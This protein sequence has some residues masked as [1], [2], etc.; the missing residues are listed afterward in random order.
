MKLKLITC[1]AAMIAITGCKSERGSPTEQA[2]PAAEAKPEAA[3]KTALITFDG[4]DAPAKGAEEP[5]VLLIEFSDFQCGYCKKAGTI[6]TELKEAYPNDLQI[7][8]MH[9]PLPMHRDAKGAAA[10]AVAAHR[11]GKFW[12]MHDKMFDNMRA[13]KGDKLAGYAGELGLDLEKFKADTA[14]AAVSKF[15][16]R[17]SA[18]AV[19]VGARGTPGFFINGKALKGF[20]PV[21]EFKKI[22][23]EE[24][25]AADEAGKKGA[26]WIKSRT[27]VNNEKLASYLFD[28]KVPPKAPERPARKARPVDRTVYKVTVDAKADPSKGKADAL[29]TIVEF[30]EF[31]CPFCTRLLPTTKKIVETYG[32]KVRIVFKHNPLPFHKDA[33]LASEAAMCAHAQGKFWEMHDELFANQRALGADKL[34]G[35]ADKVG[36][37]RKKFDKCLGDHKMKAHI[38]ADMDLGRSVMVRGTPNTFVNGRKLTGA[39][40][41]EEFKAVIDEELKKAEA[42]I[43][44]GTKA[45]DLYAQIIKDGKTFKALEDEVFPFDLSNAAVLGKPGAKIKVVAFSDFQCPYCSRVSAPLKEVKK[46]YGD[47]AVIAFKS[48][49]LSFH[50]QAMAASI[51]ALCAK[52]QG[53][54]WEMHD[55]LFGDQKALKDQKWN[56][57]AKAIGLDE[58][59]FSKC[60]ETKKY[61]DQV[62]AE[63]AEGRKAKVRGTPSIYINGRKFQSPSGYNLAAFTTV[64]DKEI[65]GK[66]AKKKRK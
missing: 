49:P 4:Q 66:G 33:F 53:K 24:I 3:K 25:K 51:A 42:L 15:V 35:Y 48:F 1:L 21:A 34:G 5:K 37:D 63:M 29:V 38:E 36:L 57:Y 43:A 12:E 20:R 52:D 41:F 14:D 55:Q 62:K 23:D 22:V 27:K 6:L 32:D 13:L 50:K 28:G 56:E 10:A 17:N 11:Q 58:G 8:Y 64:I 61:E 65:L 54:F 47:K 26:D 59:K 60:M 18:I 9:Q 7:V 44:K 40:P 30:S 45:K 19:A 46:H 39:K 31:Q 2:V 16:A